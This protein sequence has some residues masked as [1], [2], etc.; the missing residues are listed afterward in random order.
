MFLA[1]V[2]TRVGG[3]LTRILFSDFAVLAIAVHSALYIFRPGLGRVGE[4]GLFRYR[5]YVYTAWF[6]FSVIM[7]SLAFVNKAPAYTAQGTFCYL[8]IRLVVLLPE[9]LAVVLTQSSAGRSG[10]VWL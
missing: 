10:F 1:L 5:Y 8:P 2:Y 4:G 6:I 7:P 9:S 3:K